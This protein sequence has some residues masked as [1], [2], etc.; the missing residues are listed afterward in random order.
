VAKRSSISSD[1]GREQ[2]SR[3][4]ARSRDKLQSIQAEACMRTLAEF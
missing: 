3:R 2:L 4:D 1:K